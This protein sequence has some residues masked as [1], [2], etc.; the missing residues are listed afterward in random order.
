M[1][2]T[3]RRFGLSPRSSWICSP[4]CLPYCGSAPLPPSQLCIRYLGPAVSSSE[5]ARFDCEFVSQE[6]FIQVSTA[7]TWTAAWSS[8]AIQRVRTRATVPRTYSFGDTVSFCDLIYRDL[9][10]P[11]TSI[12]VLQ[13][14]P[15]L[16]LLRCFWRLEPLQ[17]DTWTRF[18]LPIPRSL[19][20]LL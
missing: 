2:Y 11:S 5:Y 3:I 19:W 20:L 16:I 14:L 12:H 8:N 17:T 18:V 4:C 15:S 9:A 1:F 13:G 7:Q 6:H 10:D